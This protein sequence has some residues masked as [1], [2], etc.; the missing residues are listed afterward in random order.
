M[1]IYVDFALKIFF[2]VLFVVLLLTTGDVPFILKGEIGPGG[3]P[4]SL[5]VIMIIMTAIL[6][7][8]SIR[9]IVLYRAGNNLESEMVERLNR[10][11][12]VKFLLAL[13]LALLYMFTVRYIGYIISTFILIEGTMLL[14]NYEK[15]IKG[16]IIVLVVVILLT[17]LFGNLMF[18][19]LPRGQGFFRNI[20]YLLY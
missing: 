9:E 4:I 13:L 12:K 11:Q 1:N 6:I 2:L 3:W 18:V 7:I 14:M 15:K 19:P 5:L 16:L 17:L 8:K 20:S 10:S